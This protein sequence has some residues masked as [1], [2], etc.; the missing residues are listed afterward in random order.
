MFPLLKQ[1]P[2]SVLPNVESW[3]PALRRDILID[4]PMAKKKQSNQ[5][6][7]NEVVKDLKNILDLLDR[8]KGMPGRS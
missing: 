1:S 6:P 3:T 2:N 5:D 7:L 8:E 4:K